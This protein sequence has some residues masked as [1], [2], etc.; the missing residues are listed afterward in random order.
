MISRP[1]HRWL[2][3][4]RWS[5]AILFVAIA[6][7]TMMVQFSRLIWDRGPI[8]AIDLG[9]FHTLVDGWFRDLPVYVADGNFTYPPASYVLLWPLVGDMLLLLTTVTLF[10]VAK[11]AGP[12]T[13]SW[14]SSRRWWRRARGTIS[15]RP[16]ATL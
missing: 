16:G 4:L 13:S 2:S 7:R 3:A 11:R 8:G 15:N 14:W 5:A 10:R 12:S 6:G 1:P 9:I